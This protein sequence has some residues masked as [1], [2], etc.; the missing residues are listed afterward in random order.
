MSE[1]FTPV[2]HVPGSPRKYAPLE[3]HLELLTVGE[4]SLGFADIEDI[5]GFA[6]PASAQEHRAWWSNDA[7][8]SQACAWLDA[9]WRVASVSLDAQRVRFARTSAPGRSTMPSEEGAPGP[10]ASPKRA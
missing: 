5:L 1:F 9:G 3:R 6:L 7:S 4:I 2:D 10:E 8:H